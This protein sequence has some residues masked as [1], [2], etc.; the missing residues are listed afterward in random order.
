MT[1]NNF[2]RH[3]VEMA[4]QELARRRRNA[5]Q[6]REAARAEVYAKVPEIRDID[7]EIKASGIETVKLM[8][9]GQGNKKLQADFKKRVK[10]LSARKKE[11]LKENGFSSK[12]LDIKYKCPSCRDTGE[13]DGAYC[14]CRKDIIHRLTIEASGLSRSKFY[15]FDEFN[16]EYYSNDVVEHNVSARINAARVLE[17]CI[18]YEQGNIFFYGSTGL[19]KTFL[20]C[21]IAGKMLQQGKIVCYISAPKLFSILSDDHFGRNQS[22]ETGRKIDM[23]Y[24]A[25]YL[26]IDDLGTEFHSSFTESCLFDIV[27]TRMEEGRN[28]I[29]NTNVSLEGIQ[30]MYSER[31][32]SRLVG[33][34]QLI[35]LF[36]E[37]I[38]R[39]KKR[40]KK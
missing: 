8:T 35:K 1:E 6:N 26:V 11:L 20:S 32:L 7:N 36:G 27:N 40:K 21:C 38:R 15:S 2:S 30:D 13:K 3:I 29:I 37:D 4:E 23:I 16:L 25:D 14:K 19:G 34:Y 5:E 12:V 28:T 10:E 24:S 33:E 39:V 22:E 17:Y 18:S 9:S 31:I